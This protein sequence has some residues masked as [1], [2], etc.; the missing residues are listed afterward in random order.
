MKHFSY[1][2]PERKVR[3]IFTYNGDRYQVMDGSEQSLVNSEIGCTMRDPETG[4]L[5]NLCAFAS[6]CGKVNRR[7]QGYCVPYERKDGRT[8]YFKKL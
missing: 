3:E 5:I 1:Q 4:N 8:V 6:Y 7:H 2:P